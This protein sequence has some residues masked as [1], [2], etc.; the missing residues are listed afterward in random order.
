MSGMQEVVPRTGSGHGVG[1]FNPADTVGQISRLR[2]INRG[3][4]PVAVTI[5]GMDD[6][7]RS[8]GGAVRLVVAGRGSRQVTA[9]ELESGEGKDCVGRWGTGLGVGGCG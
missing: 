1:L 6:R 9:E 5:E 8:P 2:L 7:G 4:K 3:V